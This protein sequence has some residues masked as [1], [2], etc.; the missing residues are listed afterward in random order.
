MN[1]THHKGLHHITALAGDPA[2]NAHFYIQKLGMRM[3]KKSVNQDDPHTYHLFYGNEAANPGSSITFFPWPRAH[4]GVVGTGEAVNVAFKVP[5][6]TESFWKYRLTE[7]GIEFSEEFT[8][9]GK[10]A[11]RFRD[12]DGMELDLVFDGTAKEKQSTFDSTVSAEQAIQGFWSTRLKLAKTEGTADILTSILG[13]SEV[14][15]DNNLTLF[16][17][18]GTIGT[19]VIL[20]ESTK[21][22]RGRGGRGTVHHVAFRAENLDDLKNMREQ[23]IAKGL[24]PSEVIDRHWFNSVYFREPGGVLFELATD[25]PGYAV[26]EDFNHLGEQLILPPWLEARRTLIENTLPALDL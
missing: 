18:E 13:F 15:A 20:E 23:V 11:I 10:P 1:M 4:K 3:V 26:D 25:D 16:G 19:K 2:A 12:P 21:E 22:E 7:Q 8:I 5:A 6:G 17:S 24:N 9:F 14:E